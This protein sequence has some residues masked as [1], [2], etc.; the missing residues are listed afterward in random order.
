MDRKIILDEILQLLE[1]LNEQTEGLKQFPEP[2]PQIE[3]DIIL[4]N[5]R[6]LYEKYRELGNTEKQVPVAE[7]ITVKQ[8]QTEKPVAPVKEKPFVP[9][10]SDQPV[11]EKEILEFEKSMI[12]ESMTQYSMLTETPVEASVDKPIE[13]EVSQKKSKQQKKSGPD[14]FTT[15][16]SVGEKFKDDKKSLNEMLADAS[17]P[18]NIAA[19]MQKNPI[20][21]L[22][23]AIGINEKFMFINELFEGSLQK[24][25]E[26]INSLNSQQSQSEAMKIMDVL[27]GEFSWKKDSDAYLALADLI[28][29]RYL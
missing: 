26:N 20:K 27:K 8:E 18:K 2:L 4:S 17:G 25:N 1:T 6:V 9:L 15:E 12:V 22:K 23:T 24:Y 19:K 21:D 28:N 3:I 7:K 13:Q 14:L 5:I 11:S 29:R 10:L 16:N